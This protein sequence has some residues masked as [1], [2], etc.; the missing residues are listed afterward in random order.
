MPSPSFFASFDDP[1]AAI[2]RARP[3]SDDLTAARRSGATATVK[4]L[5]ALI[6]P[7]RS[8]SHG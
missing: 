5:P 8:L 2:A 3:N 4:P 7:V 1:G 6:S